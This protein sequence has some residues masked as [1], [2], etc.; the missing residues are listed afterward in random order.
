MLIVSLG[1]K[2]LLL[3]QKTLISVILIKGKNYFINF[4]K[5]THAGDKFKYFI[6][7]L[8]SPL[9]THYLF[10]S[11]VLLSIQGNISSKK[12]T[13]LKIMCTSIDSLPAILSF[14]PDTTVAFKTSN[15]TEILRY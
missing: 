5:Y 10:E 9:R 1:I 14:L 13:V 15:K 3:E 2:I 4:I 12:N 7:S 11:M 8:Y 6:T